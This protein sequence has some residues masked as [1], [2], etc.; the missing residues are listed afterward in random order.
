MSKPL[1][2]KSPVVR[3]LRSRTIIKEYSVSSSTTTITTAQN[4]TQ[5]I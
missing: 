1:N 5:V 3:K 2:N 4:K